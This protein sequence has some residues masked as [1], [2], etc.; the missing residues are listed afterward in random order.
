MLINIRNVDSKNALPSAGCAGNKN[1]YIRMQGPDQ[2]DTSK[3]L[4][5]D[6]EREQ[7]WASP[8]CRPGPVPARL[9]TVILKSSNTWGTWVTQSVKHLTLDFNSGHDVTIHEFEPH[10]GLCTDSAE[11]AW[12]SLSPSLFPSLLSKIKKH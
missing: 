6:P 10:I 8:Q 7:A 2:G 4:G 5:C 11:P 9:F 12:D 3:V 1:V